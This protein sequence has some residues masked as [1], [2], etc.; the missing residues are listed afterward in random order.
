MESG[1][2]LTCKIDVVLFSIALH[3]ALEPPELLHNIKIEL[4]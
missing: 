4:G 2:R 3:E 1:R